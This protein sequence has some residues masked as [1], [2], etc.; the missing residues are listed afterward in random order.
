MAELQA[1]LS[2]LVI[3]NEALDSLA[4]ATQWIISGSNVPDSDTLARSYIRE[5][6]FKT[7]VDT[8]IVDNKRDIVAD[9]VKDRML[10][11]QDNTQVISLE[12]D[13]LINQPDTAEI[14][15]EVL[16]AKNKEMVSQ[17]K[18]NDSL[19]NKTN[20][21]KT[22]NGLLT[23]SG[24]RQVSQSN[25]SS[26]SKTNVNKGSKSFLTGNPV[27]GPVVNKEVTD[28][29]SDELV[30]VKKDTMELQARI[31][32]PADS[33]K[34][35]TNIG[36]T[37]NDLLTIS[38]TKQVS[39]PNDSLNNKT[40]ISQGSKSF[41]TGNAVAVPVVNN[42]NK[43][44]E[45]I[46]LLQKQIKV[47]EDSLKNSAVVSKNTLLTASDTNAISPQQSKDSV[48]NKMDAGKASK[49]LPPAS[50]N[51]EV[52]KLRA[53]LS[54][55][56]K[57][58]ESLTNQLDKTT[59]TPANSPDKSNQLPGS[60]NVDSEKG[61]NALKSEIRS[62]K[63][64]IENNNNQAT[65]SRRSLLPAVVPAIGIDVG[66]TK[67]ETVIQHDTVF[68]ERPSDTISHID[69]VRLT[70]TIMVKDTLRISDTVEQIVRDTVQQ[71][72]VKDS[73]VTVTNVIDKQKESLLALPPYV[74]LFDLGK[75]NVKLVYRKR[76]DYYASQL[77]QHKDL[78]IVITGHTDKTGSVA[79]NLILSENRAKSIS[80]YLNSKGVSSDDMQI[81][82][83]GEAEPI[84]ENDTKEGQSQNRR[85][86][87]IFKEK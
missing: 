50:D 9:A 2:S 3:Q 41:L 57:E 27:I 21:G 79:N 26:D 82:S 7:V 17:L 45:D 10:E 19:I 4:D 14:F 58:N 72:I 28:T 24:T 80:A 76:L 59:V 67:T 40:N 30:R 47:L 31:P 78:K 25:D 53:E 23:I 65:S 32:Y 35:T 37:S 87:L 33:L 34:N 48:K 46:A 20:A 42:D 5:E 73:V 62:L 15:D 16:I 66:K 68:V 6:T 70:D 86:E 43:S 61:I 29:V 44:N 36:K 84:V 39:Q 83:L 52:S 63:S 22:P 13:S 8:S 49:N 75:S 64:T 18:S 69:T 81:S 60:G 54:A 77:M 55:L 85:V 71:T 38:G 51:D 74:I 11:V 12:K 56:Q 1:Q